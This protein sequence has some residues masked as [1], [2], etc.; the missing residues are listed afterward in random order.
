MLLTKTL[1]KMLSLKIKQNTPSNS[2]NNQINNASIPLYKGE[3]ESLALG[4]MRP[5]KMNL[6]S[7]DRQWLLNNTVCFTVG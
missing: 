7:T 3:T 5:V 2:H 1:N 6:L 4:K